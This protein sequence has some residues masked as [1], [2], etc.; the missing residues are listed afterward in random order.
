MTALGRT[1]VVLLLAL[2]LPVTISAHMKLA[3]TLPAADATLTAP[4]K[5]IQLWFTEAPDPAVSR[6]TL[7]GPNG[8]VELGD[9]SLGED[10]SM[11]STLPAGVPDGPYV[12]SWQAAGDDGH[13]QKGAFAFTLKRPH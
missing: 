12:V 3:R 2:S 11:A 6:L 5:T 4:P 8:A 9:L 1:P 10:K 7:E 13:I